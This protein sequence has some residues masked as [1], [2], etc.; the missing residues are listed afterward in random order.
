MPFHLW[1]VQDEQPF[2]FYVFAPHAFYE[3]KKPPVIVFLHGSG[4]RGTDPAL[5]V[6]GVA[7]I[8]D[9]LQIPA[10]ILFPQC[11]PQHRSFK[12]T[13][14][15]RVLRAIDSVAK[16]SRADTDRI[17]LVGYS[18]GGASALHIATR[19]PSKFAAIIGIAPG[20]SWV[21]EPMHPDKLKHLPMWF[22]QGTEDHLCPLSDIHSLI[23]D[24]QKLGNHPKLTEYQ[25]MDHECLATALMEPGLF[26]WLLSKP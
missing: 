8:V 13:M 24:L 14:E 4:E 2:D 12:G 7:D 9:Y 19:N 22:L 15:D 25:G 16:E 23:A 17:Y 3:I 6:S 10:V 5:A 11:D 21:G 26:D 20:I 18:M 1:H